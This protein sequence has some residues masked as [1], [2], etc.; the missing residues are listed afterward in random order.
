NRNSMRLECPLPKFDFDISSDVKIDFECENETKSIISKLTP[1]LIENN[2]ILYGFFIPYFLSWNIKDCKIDV[3]I[4]K[5]S[6]IFIEIVE[7]TDVKK[8]DINYQ[9]LVFNKK[10]SKQL[11]G[12]NQK[13]YKKENKERHKIYDEISSN[14]FFNNGFR[15][16]LEN[17]I[18][19]LYLTSDFGLTREWFLTDGSLYS[20]D[21]HFGVD[22][23]R[24]KG[25]YI[26]AVSDGIVKY[27]RNNTEYYGNMII[28][29]H[30]MSFFT[31]YCHLDKIYVKEGSV[32]KKNQIIGTV[33]M[34]GAS[35]GPHLHWG[36]RIYGIPVDPRSFYKIEEIFK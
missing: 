28:L 16:P 9:K 6:D 20:K 2:Y 34:T 5:N 17:E 35:T 26:Y 30:G 14:V 24:K 4:F 33:G 12:A 13:K 25:A 7:K 32:I 31:E 3:K 22:Y 36:A 10:K 8:N 18:T 27:A 11:K 29:E 23:A 19:D 15:H 1:I 21:V